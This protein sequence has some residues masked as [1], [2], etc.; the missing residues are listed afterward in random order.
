MALRTHAWVMGGAGAIGLTAFGLYAAR[1]APGTMETPWLVIG[2]LSVVAFI[3][4]LTLDRHIIT[5]TLNARSTRRSGG[6]LLLLVGAAVVAVG[7]NVLAA[8]HDTRIDLTSSERYGLSEQTI[9]VLSAL[10]QDVEIRA[11]FSGES[12]E[13]SAF[14]DLIMGTSAHT[15]RIELTH[16]NPTLDAAAAD[17]DQID[18][19]M[20]TVILASG[21]STQRLEAELGEEALV[22]AL[23]RL[24]SSVEHIICSTD[25]HGE[26]DIDDD[27]N[28]ASI[29]AAVTKLEQQNYTFKRVN[30]MQAGGVPSECELLLIPDPRL[31]F[32]AAEREHLMAHHAA[33]G[34]MLALLEP[35]HADG[36][37]VH[38]AQYG[39]EVGENLVL[40]NNPNYQIMGG[41]AST[42]VI[43]QNQMTDHPITEPIIGMVLMRVART[44]QAFRP[45]IDGFDVGEILLTSEHAWGETR[46]DGTT[47]PEP[48]PDEDRMGRL[49]LAAVSVAEAGGVVVVFGDSDFTSNALLDQ[50]SNYD[51]LPNTIAWLLG[52]EDQVSI[53][54]NTAARGTFTMSGAQGLIIWLVSLLLLP[55][56]TVGG[57]IAT[58][59]ARRKR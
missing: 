7:I 33:G 19:T 55:A 35:G 21:E 46:I 2:G 43:G 26:I 51:L 27:L 22:N 15:Q 25:G 47:M 4:W 40:E 17:R 36:L 10:A 6:G 41:D 28:P 29:S 53:R 34:R 44:V 9:S 18:G 14:S 31:D 11:Y 45:P 23:I 48:D 1:M 5:Q 57:A 50:A 8:K 39:I 59:L 30:L 12:I 3:T 32:L 37:A 24:T 42:L 54:T 56:L 16:L 13:K 52:E 58:W 49:G 38:M 20:G